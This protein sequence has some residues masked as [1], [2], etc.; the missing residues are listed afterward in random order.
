MEAATERQ[1][2]RAAMAS[3]NPKTPTRAQAAKSPARPA[4]P[5]RRTT[6]KPAVPAEVLADQRAAAAAPTV[7]VPDA[8]NVATSR[9][10]SVDY[11]EQVRIRAYFLSLAR[12]GRPGNPVED[13]L[14]A[15]RELGGDAARNA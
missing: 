5:R 13:W 1:E 9:A 6:P 12:Q 4:A 11:A 15:E 2:H 14:A 3:K 7:T 8:S 10:T